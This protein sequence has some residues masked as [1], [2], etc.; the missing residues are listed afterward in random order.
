M[1]L[2][3]IRS[4]VLLSVLLAVGGNAHALIVNAPMAIDRVVTVQM[5]QTDDGT[6][7]ATLFGTGSQQTDILGFIDQIWAQAGIDIE[8]LAP[9][10]YSNAF[11]Y[12]GT[13]GLMN[14]RPV[15]D[16]SAIQSQGAMAGV[17]N[18][19]PNVLDMYFVNIVPG[20]S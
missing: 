19:N 1:Y 2:A 10:S 7:F 5:I 11:A 9:M 4:A 18:S 13:V 3:N 6:N 15:S 8:F 16:L 20:S 12:E 14:P 17:N